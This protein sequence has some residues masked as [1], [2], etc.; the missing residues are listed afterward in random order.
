MVKVK[1]SNHCAFSVDV[2]D[3]ISL[4]MRDFFDKP[5]PQTNQVDRCT[6]I[7]LDLLDK[8]DTKGT[9]FIL[10]QVAEKFPE[11]IKDIAHMGHEIGVHGYD[12]LRFDK[13]TPNQA[14]SELSRAKKI[15]EDR[16]GNPIFGHRAPAFSIGP[17]QKW[18]FDVIE[19][20]GFLYDSSIMPVKS[21]HYGWE[22]YDASISKIYT[23]SGKSLWE[24]PI[25]TTS[26]LTKKIPFSGGSYLRLLPYPFLEKA[27][28]IESGKQPVI[29]YIHPYELDTFKYPHYYFKELK[30]TGIKK[31]IKLRS[32][33]VNRRQ[34]YTKLDLLLS[35]FDF[36]P[37]KFLLNEIEKS[38]IN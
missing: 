6:R 38:Q 16:S 20:C 7:I 3:G 11:L 5:I 15:L 19:E 37:M 34:V 2:E 32:N 22:G 28:K 31:N 25:N 4:A 30:K 17:N 9:F 36:V 33:W 12:H 35:K 14:K 18:A 29:L 21:F 13:M 8:R 26:I 23:S 24:I 10:G 27:F 1:L